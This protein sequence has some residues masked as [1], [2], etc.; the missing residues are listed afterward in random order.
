MYLAGSAQPS[1]RCRPPIC[2]SPWRQMPPPP[3]H[4]PMQTYPSH[5][6]CDAYWEANPDP[7][8]RMTHRCK[9]ITLPKLRLQALKIQEFH[10]L[11]LKYSCKVSKWC[12]TMENWKCPYQ[13]HFKWIT[14]HY[15]SENLVCSNNLILSGCNT[16]MLYLSVARASNYLIR[17]GECKYMYVHVPANTIYLS[18]KIEYK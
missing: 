17:F 12:S 13:N 15:L 4:P 11:C 1:P 2:R 16:K 8:N 7:V 9:N 18:I 5:V 14:D 3:T 10:I 6:T